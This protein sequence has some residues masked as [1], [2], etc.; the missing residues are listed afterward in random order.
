[1]NVP[2]AALKKAREAASINQTE[3]AKRLGVSSN[4]VVSR[5]ESSETTDQAMAERYLKAI[6]TEQSL[7]M[8][9]YYSREWK[10]TKRPDFRHP[11]R[12]A[13][14]NT[15]TALQSLDTFESGEFD[16]LLTEPLNFL[17]NNLIS[18][19]DYVWQTDHA[20][21][22]IGVVGIGKTTALSH[23]TNLILRGPDGRP[24]PIFPASG[25]RTTTSEVVV[26]PGPAFGVAVEP[27]TEDEIRILVSEIVDAAVDGKGGVSTEIDRAIRNM[28]DLPKSR[29]PNDPKILID[30]IKDLTGEKPESR[31]DVVHS[32]ILRMKLEQRTET[33]LLLSENDTG[34]LE[35][36]SKVVTDIN[37][38]RHARFSLPQKVTVFVPKSAMRKS[39][40]DLTIIDTKGIH[41]ATDRRDLQAMYINPRTLNILCCAFNDAPGQE[42]LNI[43]K[44]LIDAGSDAIER[45]RVMLLVLPRADEALKVINGMGDQV[46]SVAEGYAYRTSQI[47]DTL[48]AENIPPIPILYF[49]AIEDGSA[50]TWREISGNI[51]VLRQ[52]QLDRLSRFTTLALDFHNNADAHKIQQAR[53]TLAKEG[54]NIW[55]DYPSVPTAVRAAHQGL[56]NELQRSHPSTIAAA[57]IRKGSWYNLDI[58]H[59]IGT[60]V[61]ADANLRTSGVIKRIQGRLDALRSQFGSTSEALAL[62][63][64]LAEDL[65][66]WH[67]DFLVRAVTIGK[68]A[69]KPYLDADVVFWR[70]LKQRWGQGS[71]YR[72][73]IGEMMEKWFEKEE[74]NKA[75]AKIDR[76]LEEA[77]KELVLDRILERSSL[78]EAAED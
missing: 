46:E 78:K 29:D 26:R 56:I 59:L 13:L 72:N 75:R 16:A 40:F 6:G 50:T 57:V 33:Q 68:N 35:W 62:V 42:T 77:W 44:G 45:Q 64:T 32:I 63:D 69:F 52:R 7:A 3:M 48:K 22:W 24:R 4:S 73:V 38:G 18:T 11:N 74:L 5:L 28:A 53:V 67:Q 21:A 54:Q 66:D 70:E 1:M 23:L 39:A 43:L 71:G 76:R 65:A 27:K 49:N 41:G 17:R 9:D 36:L 30:P 20:L 12:D 58:H 15:E 14:W 60:G 37:F 61:R 2:T 25:G 10:I 34:G 8:L 51:D 31:E 55:N 19:A 47:L